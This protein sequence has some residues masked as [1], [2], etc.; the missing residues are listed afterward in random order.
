MRAPGGEN[1]PGAFRFFVAGIGD[2][3]KSLDGK[4][5]INDAGYSI[6]LCPGYGRPKI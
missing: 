4:T 6:R 2:P 3:G 1:H 5:G